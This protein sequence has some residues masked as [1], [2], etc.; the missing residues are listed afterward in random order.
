MLKPLDISVFKKLALTAFTNIY[1]RYIDVSWISKW[2]WW[3]GPWLYTYKAQEIVQK[4]SW[5]YSIC[6]LEIIFQILTLGRSTS[7]MADNAPIIL[8]IPQTT[9]ISCEQNTKNNHIRLCKVNK[10]RQV[11]E[12]NLYLEI[13][14]HRWVSHFY[15]D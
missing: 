14:C 13:Y 6:N 10:S 11:Q 8:M 5:K 12:S 3:I 2:T 4:W 7:S 15:G 1:F 9:T